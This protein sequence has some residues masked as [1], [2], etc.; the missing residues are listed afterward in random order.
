MAPARIRG[1]LV[2]FWQ[3]WVVAGKPL[4]NQARQYP[5]L[6]SSRYLLG[7]LRQ[8]HRQRH[9]SHSLAPSTRLSVHPILRPLGRHIFLP[10]VASLAY[11]EPETRP[12]LQINVAFKSTSYHRSERLLLFVCHL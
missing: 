5:Y 11:E 8:R 3:L 10:R 4:R 6:R 9:W 1:A 7:F 12:R 2:M